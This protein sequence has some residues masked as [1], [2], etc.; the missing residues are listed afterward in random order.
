M[1]KQ[2]KSLQVS[3]DELA[4]HIR[5]RYP[6]LSFGFVLVDAPYTSSHAKHTTADT[7]TIIGGLEYLIGTIKGET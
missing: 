2:R 7:D 5:S 4:E 3:S 6:N 1:N